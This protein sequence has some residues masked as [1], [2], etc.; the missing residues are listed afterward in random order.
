M[1]K[2]QPIFLEDLRISIP[3]YS[4][5]RVAHHRHTPKSDLVEEHDTSLFPISSV[6]KRSGNSD[7][8]GEPIAG[9][10]GCF[11]L[12]PTWHTTWIYQIYEKPAV[13][14]GD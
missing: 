13:I 8:N 4:I 7:F 2:F 12:F 3:G 10:T 14:P 9:K 1:N 11:T 6:F 5:L